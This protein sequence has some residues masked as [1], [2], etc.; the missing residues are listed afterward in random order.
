MLQATCCLCPTNVASSCRFKADGSSPG[1]GLETFTANPRAAPAAER[2][3]EP[4]GPVPP[5]FTC[6]VQLHANTASGYEPA[7]MQVFLHILHCSEQL[8]N[9]VAPRAPLLQPYAIDQLLAEWQRQPSR[10]VLDEH[11]HQ[12]MGLQGILGWQSSAAGTI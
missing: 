6:Q 11:V 4:A 10:A 8:R 3:Q 9:A 7:E 5:L 2:R 12:K 1:L